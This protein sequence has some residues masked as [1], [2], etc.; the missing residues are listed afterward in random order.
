MIFTIKKLYSI[1]FAVG[2]EQQLDETGVRLLFVLISGVPIDWHS[3]KQMTR[4][5]IDI[6][7]ATLRLRH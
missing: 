5:S 6:K 7:V 2:N 3:S 4:S 1:E